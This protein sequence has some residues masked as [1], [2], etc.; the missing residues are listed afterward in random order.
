MPMST[1]TDSMRCLTVLDEPLSLSLRALSLRALSLRALSLRA[2]SLR[3]PCHG[4]SAHS[5]GAP[6]RAVRCSLIREKGRLPK[7]P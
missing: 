2:L 6:P 3:E 5:M 7:K 1:S 4:G